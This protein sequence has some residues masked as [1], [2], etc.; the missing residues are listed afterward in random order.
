MS[1]CTYA[2]SWVPRAA[3][4]SLLSLSFGAVACDVGAQVVRGVGPVVR[5][6][7]A[8]GGIA[9]TSTAAPDGI[10]L[11]GEVDLNVR[12]GRT[13]AVWIEGHDD[14]IGFVET[15]MDDAG[16]RVSVPSAVRL[17][18][19]PHV[20]VELPG[21]VRLGMSGSGSV[22]I[23]GVQGEALALT[24]VGSGDLDV[25]GSVQRVTLG[26]TGSGDADLDALLAEEVKVNKTGSGAA[27]VYAARALD[28][29][30]LGSGDLSYR[31][32]ASDVRVKIL[33][34]GRVRP[35]GGAD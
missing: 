8:V 11:S 32:G 5:E 19:P 14:L 18:P 10:Q 33:G 13:F 25:E 17:V 9:G 12:V 1:P 29:E 22:R 24:L 15:R 23:E 16:L 30:I 31:G 34:S 28:G 35:L 7:R 4:L 21:L 3:L 6:A 2:P 27:R 20:E 26:M